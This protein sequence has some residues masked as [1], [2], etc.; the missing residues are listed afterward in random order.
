MNMSSSSWKE[1]LGEGGDSVFRLCGVEADRDTTQ[2]TRTGPHSTTN[3][4]STPEVLFHANISH[5]QSTQQQNIYEHMHEGEMQTKHTSKGTIN[6]FK[7]TVTSTRNTPINQK[8][9]MLLIC[10]Q[11]TRK[12]LIIMCVTRAPDFEPKT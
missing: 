4:T 2:H 11:L 10:T 3:T 9:G 5:M 12:H 6:V 7:P 8:E 1:Y